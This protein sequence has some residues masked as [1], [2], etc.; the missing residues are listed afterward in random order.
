L[1]AHQLIV[2]YKVIPVLQNYATVASA[3]RM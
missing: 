2:M 1:N 3:D